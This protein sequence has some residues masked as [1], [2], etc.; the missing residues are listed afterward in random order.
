MRVDLM[1]DNPNAPGKA[2]CVTPRGKHHFFGYYDRCPWD[3]SNR[4][5]LSLET[6]FMDRVPSGEDVAGIGVVD[7]ARDRTFRRIAE[8]RA[9]NF[10]EGAKL[11][12]L[13]DRSEPTFIHNDRRNDRFV[14]VIRTVAGNEVAV[15][16]R[17]VYHVSGDGKNALSLNFSRVAR[18]VPGYGYFGVPDDTRSVLAPPDDGVWLMQLATGQSELVIPLSA[19][20]EHHPLDSMRGAEHW[21]MH[22]LFNPSG[23]R[24]VFIHRWGMP[25]RNAVMQSVKKWGRLAPVRAAKAVVRVVLGKAVRKYFTGYRSR[26]FV[27]NTDGSGLRCLAD[28]GMVSH[29]S[30]RDDDHLLV[31]ARREPI[32]NRYWLF[33]VTTGDAEPV[34]EQAFDRDGHCTFTKDGRWMLTDTYP[35]QSQHQTLILFDFQQQRRIDLGKF[36]SPPEISGTH[37]RCD[38]HPRFDREGMSICFDSTHEGNRQVYFVNAACCMEASLPP[39]CQ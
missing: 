38:L 8:T 35:N 13:D 37:Y 31:W 11:Q 24:F 16:P 34:G 21:V 32:G 28:D 10:Q 15:L 7:F 3:S 22:L 23:T 30:W 1:A 25:G 9:W 12:W 26:L 18:T 19:L 27:A 20:A 5:L 17:P 6:D 4:Y 39:T 2:V 36:F 29:Y 14:S 33:D